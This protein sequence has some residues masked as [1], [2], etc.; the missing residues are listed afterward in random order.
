L[1]GTEAELRTLE[2][3]ALLTL[4]NYVAPGKIFTKDGRSLQEIVQNMGVRRPA[5]RLEVGDSVVW[6]RTFAGAMATFYRE[7]LIRRHNWQ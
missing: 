5:R 6:K 3:L 7:T 2:G 1:Y 4:P